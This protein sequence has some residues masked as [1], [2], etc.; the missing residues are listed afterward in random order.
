[1]EV[2]N[3]LSAWAIPAVLLFV[4]VF[5]LFRRVD[6]FQTFSEGAADGLRTAV[7]ILPPLLTMLIAI[8]V[9]RDCGALD[10]LCGWL[11]RVTEPLGVPAEIVPLGLMRPLSGSGALALTADLITN[12]GVDSYLGRLSAVVQGST[13]TTFYIL[14][15]Y[16]G[17]VGISHCRHALAVGLAADLMAFILAN[18]LCTLVFGGL[19]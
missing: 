13:D 19:A 6:I 4:T 9:F 12:H 17:S 16:F 8:Y 5:A 3:V 7:S 14:A 1:M 15:V 18:L 10:I 2:I 11:E